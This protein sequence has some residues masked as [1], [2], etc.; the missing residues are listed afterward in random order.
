MFPFNYIT[1]ESVSISKGSAFKTTISAFH[2]GQASQTG[3]STVDHSKIA[4]NSRQPRERRLRLSWYTIQSAKVRAIN[5]KRAA[6]VGAATQAK[7]SIDILPSIWPELGRFRGSFCVGISLPQHCILAYVPHVATTPQSLP[8]ACRSR[9]CLYFGKQMQRAA[10]EWKV[11]RVS[12]RPG[13]CRPGA[14][15]LGPDVS[16]MPMRF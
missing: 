3:H 8:K 2:P 13:L 10:R 16:T 4:A 5:N 1:N 12:S 14:R 9:R 7:A 11:S 15:V 6:S